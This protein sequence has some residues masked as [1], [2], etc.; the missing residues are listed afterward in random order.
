MR[1]SHDFEAQ[2]DTLNAKGMDWDEIAEVLLA[3]FEKQ[4]AS[5]LVG[6]EPDDVGAVMLY[7]RDGKEIAY[8]DYERF[9]GSVFSITGKTSSEV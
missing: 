5:H 2:A 8:F 4:A 1:Y 3:Q 9:V 6:S 7:M